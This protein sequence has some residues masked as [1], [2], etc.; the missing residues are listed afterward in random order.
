M[1]CLYY[2]ITCLHQIHQQQIIQKDI[3]NREFKTMYGLFTIIFCIFISIPQIFGSD[4]VINEDKKSLAPDKKFILKDF[5]QEKNFFT[6]SN[7]DYL[8]EGR[9]IVN[10]VVEDAKNKDEEQQKM[11]VQVA[12]IHGK[13]CS[14]S[15]AIISQYENFKSYIPFV[16]ESDYRDGKVFLT[17]KAEP[18]PVQFGLD[19][20]I[21]RIKEPGIYPYLMGLGIFQGMT[22]EVHFYDYIDEKTQ[23]KK[24]F[25]FA[26]AFWQGKDTGYPNLLMETFT[27]T[28]AKKGLERL[29]IMSGH[30][31]KE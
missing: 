26:N 16:K 23:K 4:V 6:R 21:E 9:V 14:D 28:I 7:L 19:L 20:K 29:F 3:Y 15:A 27:A 1:K 31:P 17:I 30:Q 25:Y 8:L 12:G 2:L 22:G 24:C 10:S 13:N 11:I 18:I 5:L